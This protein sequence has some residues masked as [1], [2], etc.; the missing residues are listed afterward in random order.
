MGI[1]KSPRR[2]RLS[3]WHLHRCWCVVWLVI[4]Q[5][6]IPVAHSHDSLSELNPDAWQRHL[7]VYHS[8][9]CD[10]A[11]CDPAGCSENSPADDHVHWHWILPGELTAGSFGSQSSDSPLPVTSPFGFWGGVLGQ[12]PGQTDAAVEPSSA[13]SLLSSTFQNA[14]DPS[15]ALATPLPSV[16]YIT[17]TKYAPSPWSSFAQS[18]VGVSLRQLIG[19]CLV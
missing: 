7:Q 2:K 6:P 1:D 12:C 3:S 4:C 13:T 19:V 10:T 17:L 14:W 8:E 16:N 9:K 15:S 18:Y 11:D 5:F